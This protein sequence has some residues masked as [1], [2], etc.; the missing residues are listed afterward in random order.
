MTEQKIHSDERLK[1]NKKPTS[2][3]KFLRDTKRMLRTNA[4]I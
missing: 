2:T 3:S 1:R 4:L